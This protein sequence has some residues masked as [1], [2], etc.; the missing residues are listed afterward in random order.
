M[1]VV[2]NR[3]S[4]TVIALSGNESDKL[5]LMPG[6]NDVP[7]ARWDIAAKQG[8]VQSLLSA[9]NKRDKKFLQSRGRPVR[10]HL[11]ADEKTSLETLAGVTSTPGAIELVEKC[12]NR[13]LLQQWL[14]AEKRRTVK[15]A[16]RAQI[17]ETRPFDNAN[18]DTDDD[19][20]D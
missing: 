5:T 3:E 12:F 17:R 9:P 8:A 20:D 6:V 19:N 10:P 16:I 15:D 2:N 11:E 13:P 7:K 14:A 18:A 1:L 4:I